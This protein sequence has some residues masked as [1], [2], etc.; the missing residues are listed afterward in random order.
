MGVM[1]P[2]VSEGA[3][4]GPF[5]S[6]IWRF[7]ARVSPLNVSGRVPA[8]R[9]PREA[10]LAPSGCGAPRSANHRP[11]SPY[12]PPRSKEHPPFS[13]ACPVLYFK[14]ATRPALVW[15]ASLLPPAPCRS[16]GRGRLLPHALPVHQLPLRHDTAPLL[17]WL[18]R[19][20]RGGLFIAGVVL[21]ALP[22]EQ[23]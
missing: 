1:G 14:T 10:R 2:S 21:P 11:P 17:P 7:R 19:R 16:S 13:P 18:P 6:N 22:S 23:V 15:L 4:G 9:R 5:R 20:A 3:R 12:P 8:R